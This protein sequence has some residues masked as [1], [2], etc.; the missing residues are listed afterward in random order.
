M[1]ATYFTIV[2]RWKGWEL[3]GRVPA[4]HIRAS[5]SFTQKSRQGSTHLSFCKRENYEFETNL[6]YVLRLAQN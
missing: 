5:S 3:S 1:L 2:K 4:K 6:D